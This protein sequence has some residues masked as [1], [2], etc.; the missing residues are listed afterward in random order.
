MAAGLEAEAGPLVVAPFPPG[1]APLTR[2][3]PRPEALP[4]AQRTLG[5]LRRCREKEASPCR[6]RPGF[7]SRRPRPTS[8]CSTG[9]PLPGSTASSL[10]GE[11]LRRKQAQR[12]PRGKSW[13]ACGRS[14]EAAC[15]GM[16]PGGSWGPFPQGGW[17]RCSPTPSVPQLPA[18]GSAI[19]PYLRPLSSSSPPRSP[20]PLL[21]SLPCCP[22][23]CPCTGVCP[24]C[25]VCHLCDIYKSRP[26]FQD[27]ARMQG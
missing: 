25:S 24:L 1:T 13:V 23:V 18:S 16:T 4:P 7:G 26:S 20:S 22:S 12:G 2:H 9:Q 10:G 27:E 3:L 17:R 11:S 6:P 19:L 21:S 15:P 5:R 14:V 8:S